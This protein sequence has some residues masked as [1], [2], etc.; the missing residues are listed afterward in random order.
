M[1]MGSMT[2][3]VDGAAAGDGGALDGDCCANINADKSNP[4]G[5]RQA[6]FLSRNIYQVFSGRRP[7]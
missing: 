2:T 1:A 5:I 4:Q 6:A 7:L 3:G